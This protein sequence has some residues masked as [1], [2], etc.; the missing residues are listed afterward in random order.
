MFIEK[1]NISLIKKNEVV[2]NSFKLIKMWRLES[3]MIYIYV[4]LVEDIRFCITF[5]KLGNSQNTFPFYPWTTILFVGLPTILKSWIAFRVT[6]PSKHRHT[7]AILKLLVSEWKKKSFVLR[8]CSADRRE[9]FN[10][11]IDNNKKEFH[12]SKNF[13]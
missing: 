8:S 3:T 11:S 2:N 7:Q 5:L 4:V 12:F 6:K 9:P 1:I 13:I 10:I